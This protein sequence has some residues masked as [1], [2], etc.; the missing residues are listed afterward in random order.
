VLQALEEQQKAIDAQ[1]RLADDLFVDDRGKKQSK[2]T[3]T[4]KRRNG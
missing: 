2:I 4:R 1:E 3:S